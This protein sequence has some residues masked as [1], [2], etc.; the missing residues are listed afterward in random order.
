MQKNS[1]LK[2]VYTYYDVVLFPCGCNFFFQTSLIS[3][4]LFQNETKKAKANWF[5]QHLNHTV[6]VNNRYIWL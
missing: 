6:M 2:P 5:E 3:F 4:P 1:Y